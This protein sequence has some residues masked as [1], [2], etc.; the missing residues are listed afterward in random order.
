MMFDA[1]TRDPAGAPAMPDAPT[2][3]AFTGPWRTVE[4]DV[5]HRVY[6]QGG[7]PGVHAMLPHRTEMAIRAKANALGIKCRRLSRTAGMRFARR[8]PPR[9]DIDTAIRE[10]YQHAK[11]KGDIKRLVA[12]LGRPYWWVQKRAAQLGVTRSASTRLD[13]WTAPELDILERWAQC[14]PKSIALHLRKAGFDRSETAVAVKL[15]RSGIDR[16]DPDHWSATQLAALLGVKPT[17]VA[18]WVH[19]RGLP[20]R[21]ENWGPNGRLMIS[22][23]GLRAWIARC[24]RYIDLRRV[25]QVWFMD[26]VFGAAA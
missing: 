13:T 20:A 25:D 17:T 22:R 6:P 24:P 12:S 11:R 4:V 1:A 19:R 21:Q 2:M 14:H 18:D 3:P 7:A 9:D 5:L 8:Y 10:A 16:D 23:K 15:Q 26:L